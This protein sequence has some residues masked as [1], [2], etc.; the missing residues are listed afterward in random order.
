MRDDRKRTLQE[1]VTAFEYW[2]QRGLAKR[3]ANALTNAGYA[4]IEELQ[5]A[6]DEDLQIMPNLGKEGV[7]AI[8]H[9]LGR[10]EPWRPLSERP[11]RP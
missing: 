2:T 10:P 11:T 4:T 3:H 9:L 8:L 5:T 7:V 6:T 1:Q